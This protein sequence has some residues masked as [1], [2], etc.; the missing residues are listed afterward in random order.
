M[1]DY[2]RKVSDTYDS[3]STSGRAVFL[4]F[5]GVCVISS[6]SLVYLLNDSILVA[7]PAYGGSWT[8]GLIGAPRFINPILAVS[9]SDQDLTSL[10]Y[11]GLLKATPEGSY[12][13]DLA[14]SY[15]ISPD[16]K[17]YTFILRSNAT[18]DDGTPVTADDVVFTIQKAQ[19]PALNS[20]VEADWAGVTVTEIDPHTVQFTLSQPYAPFI[21]DLTLGILPKHLWENV[22]DDEFSFS[23]LNIQPVGSGPFEVSSISRTPSGIPSSY[24]LKPF[25][26]YAL[27]EPY[28][29]DMT[30]KIY[31]SDTDLV[32]ALQDGQIQAANGISPADLS[33]LQD[34]N[35]KTAPLNR[36]FG[37]FFNQNQST[38]LR[39]AQ[40]RQALNNAINRQQLISLV[41]DGYGTSLTG[42]IPP[43]LLG[44]VAATSS[45]SAF[46][47]NVG[48][49]TSAT[50]TMDQAQAARAEL[51]QDG[52]TPGPGGI[53]QKTTGK[54][55]SASTETLEF[56]LATEDIPELRSA[57]QYLSQ[58]WGE[59]G[60]QVNVEIYDQGDLEENVIRPRKYDALLFG[61]D[62]GREV[63]L[64]AFWDSSQRNDP[65]L[66]V[67]EYANATA[68]QILQQLRTTSDPAQQEQL[69]Q[70]FDAQLQKDIPAVFLYAPDFVYIVPNDVSGI[71]LGFIESPSD[72]F[73]SVTQWHQETD[74]VWPIFVKK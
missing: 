32:Q 69:Y 41:L 56:S 33:G 51:V 6:I 52:W 15:T 12:V 17:T 3:F 27:G 21:Q 49:S 37:V 42:P 9:D 61:E 54:G 53:L 65:G 30:F 35:I 70:E 62:I 26:H 63:D 16:G 71:D 1:R 60:A 4:F 59:M 31:Q 23:N 36:V 13:L 46:S 29:G 2:L 58:T 38:V 34:F 57:A 73:L 43:S 67:A 68:D 74:Y 48:T 20:P 10:V 25:P 19:D 72:R 44:T 22:T 39:D 66:N 28:L 47:L 14:Q 64:Y 40:V 18:F 50:T 7:T 8:E 5:A 11:S 45:T 24:D 55:K